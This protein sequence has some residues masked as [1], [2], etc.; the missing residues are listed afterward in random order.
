MVPHHS[1][2]NSLLIVGHQLLEGL[3]I[4]GEA[5]DVAGAVA[6]FL[7]HC[8]G[9]VAGGHQAGEA[10]VCRPHV[11]HHRLVA[12]GGTVEGQETKVALFQRAGR[13]GKLVEEEGVHVNV[14][15]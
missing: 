12:L 8:L 2:G 15:G 9:R 11:L 13:A 14:V 1:L 4:L 3:G 5:A 10:V 6:G 7:R